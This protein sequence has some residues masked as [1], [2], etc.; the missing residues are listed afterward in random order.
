[1]SV[2]SALGAVQAGVVPVLLGN[3]A[4]GPHPLLL[5]D[6]KEPLEHYLLYCKGTA[7]LLITTALPAE[8][9][10]SSHGMTRKFFILRLVILCF[11]RMF[12]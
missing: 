9:F 3:I 6:A 2:P 10:F 8:R 7:S 1:M 5:Q 11:L 4:T 12:L